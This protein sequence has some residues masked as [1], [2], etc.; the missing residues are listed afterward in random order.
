MC[1]TGGNDVIG[2]LEP[3]IKSRAATA[4]V[5]KGSLE[6]KPCES[7]AFPRP[8]I[9]SARR[10]VVALPLPWPAQSRTTHALRTANWILK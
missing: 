9:Y 10:R 3:G 8:A 4:G 6:A 1:R 2:M 5:T 7:G